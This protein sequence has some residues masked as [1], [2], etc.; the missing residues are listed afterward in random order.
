MISSENE[1][2]KLIDT[3]ILEKLKENLNIDIQGIEMEQDIK[4]KISRIIEMKKQAIYMLFNGDFSVNEYRVNSKLNSKNIELTMCE[5]IANNILSKRIDVVLNN[6]IENAPNNGRFVSVCMD[7]K[8]FMKQILQANV[9][10]DFI[11]SCTE[12]EKLER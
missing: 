11:Y 2:V 1:E 5:R 3:K 9:T 10:P 12:H 4:D 7:R 6:M 8:L